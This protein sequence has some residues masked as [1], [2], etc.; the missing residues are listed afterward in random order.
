MVPA[1]IVLPVAVVAALAVAM[2]VKVAAEPM[3]GSPMALAAWAAVAVQE[4]M[5]VA[6]AVAAAVVVLVLAD[7][8]GG[9]VG[10]GTVALWRRCSIY[11]GH[12]IGM[13]IMPTWSRI[14]GLDGGCCWRKTKMEK[15]G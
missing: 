3:W 10:M 5:L 8:Q 2:P 7:R 14:R 1:A 12:G 13:S 6:V 9:E 11:G 4:A 15:D